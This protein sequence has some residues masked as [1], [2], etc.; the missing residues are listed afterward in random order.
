[1]NFFPFC[2]HFIFNYILKLKTI[3]LSCILKLIT[4]QHYKMHYKSLTFLLIKYKHYGLEVTFCHRLIRNFKA[5]T[6]Y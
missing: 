5:L 2:T 4:Y 6:S 3:N 1:M